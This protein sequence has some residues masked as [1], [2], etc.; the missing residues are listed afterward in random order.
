MNAD[1]FDIRH[2]QTVRDSVRPTGLSPAQFYAQLRAEQRAGRAGNAV[3][4]AAQ[5]L[6]RQFRDER[7]PGAA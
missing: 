3:V 6:S 7:S 2:F 5:K 1:V 4:P